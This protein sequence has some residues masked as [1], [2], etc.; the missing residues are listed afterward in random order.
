MKNIKYLA[1]LISLFA[2]A[3]CK[4]LGSTDPGEV[5]INAPITLD[6]VICVTGD[7]GMGNDQQ[8]S[9]SHAME[10]YGCTQVRIVGDVVYPSGIKSVND[11]AFFDKF[12][13][14]YQNL[15][16]YEVPFYI[17]LGNH[18]YREEPSAWHDVNKKY[19]N[20][21]FPNY[22]YAE[23]WG[24]ICILS[25]D[26]NLAYR[27]EQLDWLSL[28]EEKLKGECSFSIGFGHHP[29]Y[30]DGKHGNGKF[31]V[32]NLLEKY[33]KGKLD[34]YVSGH[35]HNLSDEGLHQGTHF[36]VSGAGATLRPVKKESAVFAASKYGFVAITIN[37]LVNQTIAE[38]KF[39]VVKKDSTFVIDHQGVVVGHGI[40]E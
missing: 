11:T 22:F 35:D 6:D 26:T 4:D 13:N 33:V 17:T 10:E 3:S 1:L 15:M 19:K 12:Y 21:I 34:L 24:D 23:K 30:S 14:P 36:L 25:I 37:K 28:T 8:Q 16:F 2:L 32:K 18:D 40:R 9:V 39:I 38:F 7:V 27:K 29:L 5:L 31:F 20:I